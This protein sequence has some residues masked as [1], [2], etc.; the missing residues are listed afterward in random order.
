MTGGSPDLQFRKFKFTGSM[1]GTFKTDI[2]GNIVKNPDGTT[3]FV[4]EYEGKEYLITYEYFLEEFKKYNNGEYECSNPTPVVSSRK[5]VA[6]NSS[7]VQDIEV[8]APPKVDQAAVRQLKKDQKKDLKQYL[9]DGTFI[10]DEQG[11]L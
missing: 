3:P 2:D 8:S 1:S 7:P 11:R 9:K 5:K 6:D 4:I 10:R